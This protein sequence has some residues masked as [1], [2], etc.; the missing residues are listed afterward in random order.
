MDTLLNHSLSNFLVHNGDCFR[1]HD[2]QHTQHSD[3]VLNGTP[4]PY[5]ARAEFLESGAFVALSSCALDA[6]DR[7]SPSVRTDGLLLLYYSLQVM[8]G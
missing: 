4:K 7:A 3:G 1:I 5:R 2:C 6:I 8:S